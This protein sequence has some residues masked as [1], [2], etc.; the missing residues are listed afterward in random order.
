MI[1]NPG[2]IIEI[3]NSNSNGS[4]YTLT[5]CVN[6]LPK[7][8]GS[9]IIKNVHEKWKWL[10]FLPQEE[11][12]LLL[13][14]FFDD[15]ENVILFYGSLYNDTMIK[16]INMLSEE[17][18]KI[19]KESSLN[20]LTNFLNSLSGYYCGIVGDCK[21]NHFI[22]FTDRFGIGKLFYH[23]ENGNKIFSTNVFL[24]NEYLAKKSELSNF[25]AS[26]IIY[27]GHTFSSQ[28]II[29]KVK[30]ILPGHYI[31]FLISANELHQNDY[32]EYPVRKNLSLSQS[33]EQIANA[34]KNFWN[35]LSIYVENDITLL[36]SG[37]K[38][39]RVILKYMLTDHII[40]VILTYFREKNELYPF[41]SFLLDSKED[42]LTAEKISL[43]NNLNYSKIKIDN[44]SFAENLVDILLLN[45]GSPSHWEIFEAAKVASIKSKY[46]VSGFMGDPYAGKG[47]HHYIFGNIKN[48]IEY[49]N[50]TFNKASDI[51]SYKRVAE[52]LSKHGILNLSS[53]GDLSNEWIRQ[54][55]SVNSDDIDV[56]GAEGLLRT[57]GIGRVIPTFQQ[58]RLFAVP[59]YPYLDLE[60]LNAYLTTPAKYLKGEIAHLMQISDDKNFN[61]S[62]TTRFNV[63]AKNEKRYLKPI[64]FLRKLDYMKNDYKK[65]KDIALPIARSYN[66]A[67][68]KTLQHMDILP[69]RFINDLIPVNTANTKEYYNIV[70]NFISM[71]RIQ[72]VYFNN[73]VEV[74]ND[75]NI[76]DYKNEYLNQKNQLIRIR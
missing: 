28:T 75:L 71:M 3:K 19:A 58:A 18:V 43:R 61:Q 40:P 11:N 21:K 5:E 51:Y 22:A 35:K 76:I 2:F 15:G 72:D 33:V 8:Y 29:N 31:Q 7:E 67:L 55:Q 60:I 52:I 53:I 32:V 57:R 47:K 63:D 23:T 34:H 20:T 69:E 73:K 46:L 27:C 9:Q 17:L 36:L 38:D 54:Y 30:Q 50:F 25:A 24:M 45:N 65:R 26:S 66:I 59:V 62:P 56:I 70:A 16:N 41:V 49:G 14:L 13:S 64:A 12:K 4:E 42:S 6:K 48:N 68:R 39:C 44:I 1:D 74:R 10:Y 37:G